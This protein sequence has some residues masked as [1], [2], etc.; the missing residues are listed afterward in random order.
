MLRSGLG[1]ALDALVPASCVL[2]GGKAQDEGLCTGC[3]RD[4]P[5]LQEA[6]TICAEPLAQAARCGRCSRQ[7]PPFDRV[8][9]ALR[10]ER[11]VSDLVTRFK[12]SGNLAAGRTLGRLLGR[13]LDAGAGLA[14]EAMIPVPLH[15]RRLAERGFNQAG[16]LARD[17]ARGLGRLRIEPDL[18]V[19]TAATDPQADLPGASR[20]G[21]VRGA[22]QVRGT[23]PTAVALVDDVVTT[24]STVSECARLLRRAGVDYI[25]VW[26][27][28]RA[29]RDAF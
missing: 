24:A 22:F 29:P 28:A 18:L 15:R 21:N 6:C 23:P 26:A 9:A 7:P 1:A 16:L 25:E 27:V 13:H 2:C 3:W 5:W 8:R 10:Y 19:R 14:V 4:L 20:R 11:P 17:A 12:F